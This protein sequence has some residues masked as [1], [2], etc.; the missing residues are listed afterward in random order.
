MIYSGI[1][2]TD[3]TPWFFYTLP[4]QKKTGKYTFPVF[5][6]F[7][8]TLTCGNYRFLRIPSSSVIDM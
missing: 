2:A 1:T 6:Y 7:S 3:Y 8:F 4:I 5:E